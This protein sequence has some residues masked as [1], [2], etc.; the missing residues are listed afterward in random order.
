MED[1]LIAVAEIG[2]EARNFLKSDLCRTMLGLADQQITL[3]QEALEGADC[4]DSEA[5]R[6]L[7]NEARLGRQFSAWLN[8]L[9]QD[10]DNAMQIFQQQK[11]QS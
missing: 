7:Q 8:D 11:E 3:A 9:V 4:T 6:K 10:G 1:E 2:E 5:I